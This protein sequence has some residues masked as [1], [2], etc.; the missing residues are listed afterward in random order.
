MMNKINFQNEL[1]YL[2]RDEACPSLEL[3]SWKV[4]VKNFK[5]ARKRRNFS[6]L[7]SKEKC[8]QKS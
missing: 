1:L 5:I 7:Q 8:F 6:K 2:Q 4:V 3:F